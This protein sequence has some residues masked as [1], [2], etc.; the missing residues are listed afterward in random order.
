ML[1]TIESRS[2]IG[3]ELLDLGA[4]GSFLGGDGLEEVDR[5]GPLLGHQLPVFRGLGTLGEAAGT[6]GFI[7]GF[8]EFGFDLGGRERLALGGGAGFAFGGGL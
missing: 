2:S 1:G 6:L 4:D 5:L 7:F 3:E 8:L